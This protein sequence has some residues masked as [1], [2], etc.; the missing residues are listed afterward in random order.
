VKVIFDTSRVNPPDN[1]CKKYHQP[2]GED[3]EGSF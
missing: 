2:E 3:G 1:S